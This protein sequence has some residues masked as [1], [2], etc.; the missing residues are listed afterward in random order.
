MLRNSYEYL[1]SFFK[2]KD[3]S[4]YVT[5]LENSHYDLDNVP[6]AFCDSITFN[7]AHEPEMPDIGLDHVLDRRNH[8]KYNHINPHNRQP[9]TP[10]LSSHQVK[11]QQKHLQTLQELKKKIEDQIRETQAKLTR[12]ENQIKLI[13][14]FEA[15]VS[16]RER[17][18]EIKEELKKQDNTLEASLKDITAFLRDEQ[19]LPQEQIDELIKFQKFQHNQTI[20]LLKM[21]LAN[22]LEQFLYITAEVI[23]E[24]GTEP[25]DIEEEMKRILKEPMEEFNT[26]Q[27]DLKITQEQLMA[28]NEI[29]LEIIP[30]IIQA[31]NTDEEIDNNS[32]IEINP[33]HKKVR[34]TKSRNT[35]MV[36][37]P[38]NLPPLSIRNMLE[39][40]QH[41][42]HLHPSRP[43]SM[44]RRGIG[45]SIATH[46]L[47]TQPLGVLH[48][49]HPHHPQQN[50]TPPVDLNK[51]NSLN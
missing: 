33:S 30:S 16:S 1:L 10:I 18:Y 39:M 7:V 17:I 48:Q 13:R 42:I 46:N 28:K 40:M 43:L 29:N 45:I 37:P 24:Y 6:K 36:P 11:E 27:N 2:K 22:E 25:S 9:L 38:S 19:H 3:R 35:P 47:F 51:R 44:Y 23:V 8:G 5:R 14:Q 49:N 20:M 50:V 15:F 34:E 41:Y 21:K 31:N 32:K 26:V 12:Y 4:S